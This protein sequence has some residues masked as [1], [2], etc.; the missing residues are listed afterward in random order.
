MIADLKDT[1]ESKPRSAGSYD[2]GGTSALAVSID[3]EDNLQARKSLDQSSDVRSDRELYSA[4][5]LPN[6][7]AHELASG[8]DAGLTAQPDDAETDP[9]EPVFAEDPD[10]APASFA[11]DLEEKPQYGN[12]AEPEAVQIFQ[13]NLATEA[14]FA[15]DGEPAENAVLEDAAAAADSLD[16][17][18]SIQD[19]EAALA[20]EP[21]VASASEPEILAEAG[22]VVDE[23]EKTSKTS[24][25]TEFSATEETTPAP[26]AVLSTDNSMAASPLEEATTATEPMEEP[27]N[28]FGMNTIRESA[29]QSEAAYENAFRMMEQ[30]SQSFRTIFDEAGHS[31]AKLTFKFFEFAQANA[32]SNMEL[33]REYATVRSLPEVLDI[34]AA[35]MKRQIELLT[36]QVGE[37]RD[38]TTEIATK[39]A[40]PFK[41]QMDQSIKSFQQH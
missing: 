31:A 23:A 20:A 13:D 36:T 10:L 37:L 29:A 38:I 12:A 14:V 41:E 22:S 3:T 9:D 1:A 21:P 26:M 15:E 39:T 7:D 19:A 40:K 32:E 34:Q 33:A 6:Q 25:A 18:A 2:S 27:M 35:Y 24:L 16:D 4:E 5:L 17:P 28:E 11:A 8:A 30:A